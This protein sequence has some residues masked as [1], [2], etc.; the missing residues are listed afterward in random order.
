MLSVAKTSC[1]FQ[2]ACRLF[3]NLARF[4]AAPVE[5]ILTKFLPRPAE[6]LVQYKKRYR[7]KR[8]L[9]SRSFPNDKQRSNVYITFQKKQAGQSH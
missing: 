5:R 7:I 2:M 3:V 9:I 4:S 6:Y 8:E 1:E